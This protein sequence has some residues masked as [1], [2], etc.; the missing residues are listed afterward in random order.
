MAHLKKIEILSMNGTM[1]EKLDDL[2]RRAG[3]LF[4]EE[5]RKGEAEITG[6]ETFSTITWFRPHDISGIVDKS[7]KVIAFVG[8]DFH[9]SWLAKKKYGLRRAYVYCRL[10][11]SG[12]TDQAAK[13]VICCKKGSAFD[14]AIIKRKKRTN[15]RINGLTDDLLIDRK[16]ITVSSEYLSISRSIFNKADIDESHGTT[17]IKVK[18]GYYNYGVF[19]SDSGKSIKD[20]NLVVVKELFITP[21]L[22][23]S[24]KRNSEAESFARRIIGV[25]N[26]DKNKLFKCHVTQKVKIAVLKYLKD[27][28]EEEPER[29]ATVNKLEGHGDREE[30]YAIEIRV[31]KDKIPD[32]EKK[33]RELGADQFIEGPIDNMPPE[34]L[35]PVKLEPT[36]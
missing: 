24:K 3:Y 19:V 11:F 31:P 9:R 10:F 1:K 21:I 28:F 29:V 26:G 25:M 8:E 5:G 18:K 15:K 13:V 32:L 14:P 16:G 20:A 4:K 2:I 12:K 34:Q 30:K 7:K 35:V 36:Y 22:L 6:S 17:E 33:L 23:I 27:F